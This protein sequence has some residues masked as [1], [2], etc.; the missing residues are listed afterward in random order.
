MGR[1]L[2]LCHRGVT[3]DRAGFLEYD[4]TERPTKEQRLLQEPGARYVQGAVDSILC[5]EVHD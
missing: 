1:P 2:R 3:V 4:A 5:G